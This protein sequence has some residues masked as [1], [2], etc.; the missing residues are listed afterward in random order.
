MPIYR[1]V[2]CILYF[3]LSF[4]YL[5]A[6]ENSRELRGKIHTIQGNVTDSL[7]QEAMEFV[8]VSLFNSKGDSLITGTITAK[9]GNFELKNIRSGNYRLR[10]S[11]LG[12]RTINKDIQLLRTSSTI[13]NL[14]AILLSSSDIL[15][16][17]I[18]VVAEIPEMQVREDTVEYNAAAFRVAEGAVVEDLLKK[19][20]GIE[21]DTEGAITTASGKSVNR[22]FVDGKEFFGRDPKMATRNLNADMIDKVQVVE[23]QSDLAILTG[24]EDDDPETIINITIKKGEKKGWI[25]N[26][27]SGIG[28][29][30]QD[31]S[32]SDSRYTVNANVNHFTD[33]NQLSLIANANNINE[34]ASGNRQNA[35]SSGRGGGGG[36][37][38]GRGGGGSGGGGGGSGIVSSNVFGANT[39]NTINEKIK[40]S[41]N[42]NYNYGDNFVTRRVNRQNFFDNDSI[43]YRNSLSSSREYNNNFSFEGKM[44][45]KPDTLTTII[46]TPS[47]ARN[48]STSN[49]SSAQQT[50]IN[51]EGG[52]LA[53]ESY[54]DSR[55]KSSSTDLR[56]QL[57]LS[58]KLSQKGRR[59]SM[60]GSFA[61]SI[62]EGTGENISTTNIYVPRKRLTNLNQQSISDANRNTYNFR[63]TYVEPIAKNYFLNFAYNIQ[64]NRTENIRNTFDYDSLEMDYLHLNPEYSKSSI[65]QT[66]NQNIRVNL[67]AQLPT[68]SYNIGINIAPTHTSSKSFIDDWY[69]NGVDSI[70]Y[71]PDSRQAF[72]FAPQLEFNYRM[73]D[74]RVRKNLKFR[75]N[76]STRQPSITQL[77]PTANTTNPLNIRSGNADLL[78]SFNHNS[79][80]EYNYNDRGKQ[81]SLT[82]TWTYSYTQ[83][84]IVNFT[85][86]DDGIQHTMPINVSGSWNT[87]GSLLYSDAFGKK[88][89]FKFN[90]HTNIRYQNQIG[91]SKV[92]K[93]SVK[94]ISKT[95]S[96]SQSLGMSYSN[97]WFYGQLRG[98]MNYSNS[99]YS[100]D[101]LEDQRSF[102][103]NVSYNTQITLPEGFSVSTDIRYMANRGLSSGY[104]K[105]EVMWN[106]QISKSFLKRRQGL[107]R[108]Q[109]NDILQQR[110]SISR[111]VGSNYLSDTET[112]SLTSY[113]MLNFSYRF[114]AR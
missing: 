11:Y 96:A 32:P 41:G 95:E 99:R 18:T 81:R 66:I 58:R 29:L 79:S 92:D 102:R 3:T 107:L 35:I 78:A 52:D 76:G 16:D 83:N 28:N 40:V 62:N 6:Q 25:G 46:V 73:G 61:T 19:L 23:K 49:E 47:I 100:L 37:G 74:R 2:I 68:Y 65:N 7:Q 56:L 113:F 51:V 84:D 69:G 15:L 88:K 86:Y 26:I 43:T 112:N 8:T 27:G 67:N 72:N 57:D 21:V 39:A 5:A 93:E 90:T 24:V 44:E 59:I 71:E 48:W 111:S 60:S 54:T 4:T 34:R 106:A 108:L 70:L 30:T 22:V 64:G 75:Y 114:S 80:I 77:D 82:S 63:F 53:N 9:E 12:Y 31:I 55:L 110:L 20:P 10:I 103:Y 85:T 91:F 105:D 1:F 104:N 36:G 98:T 109:I 42:A 33:D 45:Y 17:G 14:G 50:Y 87:G 13:L 101:Y 97:D 89:R 38:G 94:N